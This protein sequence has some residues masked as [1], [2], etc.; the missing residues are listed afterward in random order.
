MVKT[1][2]AFAF[3]SFFEMVE[4]LMC[5]FPADHCYERVIEVVVFLVDGGG[6]LHDGSLR[7]VTIGAHKGNT[8]LRLVEL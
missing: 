3:S 5:R 1:E 8:K 2:L 7:S 4:C 6:R